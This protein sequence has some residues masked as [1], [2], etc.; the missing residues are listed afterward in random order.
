MITH[1]FSDN[2]YAKQAEFPAGTA[3]LKHT[4]DF[5]HLSDEKDPSKVDEILIKGE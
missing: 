3:V 1:Y 5:S 2:L 4:H